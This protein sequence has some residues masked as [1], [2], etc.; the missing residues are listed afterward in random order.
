[1]RIGV[2][3]EGNILT[4]RSPI[5]A[6][7]ALDDAG[8][9]VLPL[10][11]GNDGA[12]WQGAPGRF[13]TVEY[14]SVPASGT[15]KLVIVSDGC[16][17]D[18]KLSIHVQVQDQGG[19]WGDVA[20]IIPRVYFSTDVVDVSRYLPDPNGRFKVRLY[21]TSD[22]KLDYVGLDTS[23][24]DSITTTELDTVSATHSWYG[25]VLQK[26]RTPDGKLV[27][28]TPNQKIWL[29]FAAPPTVPAGQQLDYL[30]TSL[31]RYFPMGPTDTRA[32]GDPWYALNVT[33]TFTTGGIDKS[34]ISAFQVYAE[35][36]TDTASTDRV[37][38]Q[39]WNPGLRTWSDIG[40]FAGT[41]SRQII[42]TGGLGPAYICSSSQCG[43]NNIVLRWYFFSTNFQ[44][45][46][47][48]YVHVKLY[49]TRSNQDVVIAPY[50]KDLMLDAA[51]PSGGAAVSAYLGNPPSLKASCTSD[52][53]GSCVLNIPLNKYDFW[54]MASDYGYG[55]TPVN[56]TSSPFSAINTTVGMSPP[57][58][59]TKVFDV[60][61]DKPYVEPLFTL[62]L[63]RSQTVPSIRTTPFFNMTQLSSRPRELVA[64]NYIYWRNVSIVYYFYWWDSQNNRLWLDE[65]SNTFDWY[66]QYMYMPGLNCPIDR[67]TPADTIPYNYYSRPTGGQCYYGF[68]NYY[69][70][71]YPG[72]LLNIA[73]HGDC[74]LGGQGPRYCEDLSSPYNT[75]YSFLGVTALL[76]KPE[77][78][79][80]RGVVAYGYGYVGRTD[81]VRYALDSVASQLFS[82]FGGVKQYYGNSDAALSAIDGLYSRLQTAI[83]ASS[84]VSASTS[85]R[86]YV[87]N[88]S[89]S[90][91]ASI[92]KYYGQL[93]GFSYPHDKVVVSSG[94]VPDVYSSFMGFAQTYQKWAF[95]DLAALTSLQFEAFLDG[96]LLDYW[97]FSDSFVDSLTCCSSDYLPASLRQQVIYGLLFDALSAKSFKAATNPS[98]FPSIYRGSGNWIWANW[99]NSAINRPLSGST[100]VNSPSYQADV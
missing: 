45:L 50:R 59:S 74:Y 68:P 91:A 83:S 21:F 69:N 5:S 87:A 11:S 13:L 23:P 54:A 29:K 17:I 14:A 40:S 71:W 2:S 76:N 34:T 25:D 26:L 82:A 86:M 24:Q 41:T 78:S 51:V 63:D 32:T 4:Y 15:Y 6:S 36:S 77:M 81:P 88:Y 30:I 38:L 96:K 79:M 10:L 58:L 1:M 47:V 60:T 44:T 9:S 84:Q 31:G 37:Y 46:N 27:D 28:I 93:T 7:S 73:V 43:S 64:N 94:V 22:H 49:D 66:R 95:T 16:T 61:S 42:S 99:Y 18:C 90:F 85:L 67:Q 75:P 100:R 89:S 92:Y 56:I 20:I 72:D 80:Y 55:M 12:Y 70:P 48:D 65:E 57:G 98:L 62:V 8:S 3:P 33:Y 52:E 19:D 39:L 53:S 97:G 35:A